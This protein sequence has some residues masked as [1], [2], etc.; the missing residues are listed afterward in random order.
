MLERFGAF[1]MLVS[2][3]IPDV[4]ESWYIPDTGEV[5]NIPDVDGW[6]HQSIQ[7]LMGGPVH[8]RC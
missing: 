8:S 7:M 3:L 1:Q 4:T 6:I 2:W 5:W